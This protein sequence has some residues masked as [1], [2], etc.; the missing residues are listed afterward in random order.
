MEDRRWKTEDGKIDARAKGQEPR[1]S[2]TLKLCNFKTN[3]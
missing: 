2:K 3:R 1:C